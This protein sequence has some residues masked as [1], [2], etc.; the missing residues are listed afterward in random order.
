MQSKSAI[1]G[2]LPPFE[3]KTV[4]IVQD[5]SVKDI[6]NEILITHAE[7]EADYDGIYKQF[8]K[9]DINQTGQGIWNFLKYNLKYTAEDKGDQSVKSPAAILQDGQKIDCK[10]YSLF[11]GG[12]ID[13][14]KRNEGDG[15]EWFYRF[16]S[17]DRET[18]PSH[19]FVVVRDNGTE[20]WIDPVLS[21]YNRRK[22]PTFKTDKKPM[23]LYKISGT[24]DETETVITIN[25]DKAESDFLV[26]VNLNV[27]GLKD[28]MLSNAN[29]TYGLVKDYFK[30]EGF[31]FNNLLNILHAKK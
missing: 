12:V 16:A 22:Q 31:D 15:F 14:I 10:H 25:K 21:A 3:N 28:L 27:F 20:Y 9:G 17:Y 11:I 26:M 29:V 30:T 6:I 18:A 4:L 24:N 5:Q 7:Y 1:R 13:A 8:D 19:V 23:S 2:L